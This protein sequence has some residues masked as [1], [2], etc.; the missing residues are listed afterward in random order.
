MSN[1]LLKKDLEVVDTPI[2]LFDCTMSNGTIERWSSAKVFFAGHW[3]EPRVLD[4]TALDVRTGGDDGLDVLSQVVLTLANAD[5][6]ASQL[7]RQI[8]FKGARLLVRFVFVDM[9]TGSSSSDPLTLFRGL[10][11]A[12]EESTESA[13]RV[14]F[15]NRLS[16][17]RQLV[18]QLRIQKRC[19]WS[20]PS[21]AAERAEGVSGLEQG[22]YSPFFRCG[23]SPDQADGVGNLNGA[24]PFTS[25]DYTRGSCE[26]RGMFDQDHLLRPTRR[27]GGLEFVPASIAVRTAGEASGKMSNLLSNDARYNDF[28]PSVYGTA[29]YEP[30]I[31][32]ARNDGNLT[33]FEVLLGVGEIE[34]VVKVI[35]NDVEIPAGV[36]GAN[37]TGTGWYNTPT[38][39]NRTG[40]FNV[41]FSGA[42]GNPLG[43]PYGSMA[44]L[45]LVVPNRISDG[46]RL[47]SVKLLIQGL[48]L[49][50]F[51]N[52]GGYLGESFTSNPAWVLLDLLRRAGWTTDELDLGEFAKAAAHCDE[53]VTAKDLMG[54]DVQLSRYQCNLVLRRRRSL[55]E[56]L[57][58]VSQSA[59]LFLT[60]GP[61]GKLQAR[62]ES[63]I[64]VSQP[65]KQAGS[66]STAP[67][68]GGWPIYEFDESGIVRGER[69][70]PEFRIW[71][72]ST[73]DSPNRVTLEFQDAFNEYQQDSLSFAD[74]EDVRRTGQEI[75]A[76]TNALG[77]ANLD[78]AARLIRLQLDKSIR[79]NTYVEFESSVKALAIRPGDLITI[80]Y[81]KEG[82]SRQ[83]FRV[84]RVRPRSNYSR[85][86]IQ[87]QI[88]DEGWYLQPGVGGA[89]S[90]RQ[91]SAGI[92]TP[93][94]LVGFE[95]NADG[96]PQ[97]RVSEEA[98]DDSVQVSIQFRP[99]ASLTD[100]AAS[101]PLISLTAEVQTTG[102][103]LA[104]GRSLYYA[105]SAEDAEGHETPLSFVVRAV[106]PDGSNTNQVVLKKLS[107]SSN[108]ST[109]SVYRGDNPQQLFRIGAQLPL[110][111][112]FH[113]PGLA[114]TL[115]A[116]PDPNFHEARFYWRVEV[117]PETNA[118]Q[119]S[120]TTVGNSTLSMPAGAFDGMIVRI[121]GGRGAGQERRIATNSPTAVATTLPWS[122]VPDASS[123][124]VIAENGW[125]LG[126][127]S[128]NSPVSFPIPNRPGVT[129]EIQG[130]AANV[131][132][133]EAAPELSPLSRWQIIGAGGNGSDSGVPGTPTFGLAAVGGGTVELGGIGF[134][135]LTNTRTIAGGTLTLYFWNELLAP[136]SWAISSATTAA[137]DVISAN[138]PDPNLQ[139]GDLLQLDSEIVRVAAIASNQLSFTVERGVFGSEASAHGVDTPMY[140]L[141]KGLFVAPFVR[142]FFG[143]PASGKYSHP[144]YLPDVRIAC[145]EFFV[146]NAFGD[147]AIARGCVTGNLTKGIRTLSGGQLTFQYDGSLAIGSSLAPILVADRDHTVGDVYAVLAEPPAGGPVELEIRRN[148]AAYC[149]LTISPGFT[150]SN[151]VDGFS[152]GP[153][154]AGDRLTLDV[155]SVPPSSAGTPGRDLT[156]I[157]TR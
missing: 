80:S 63:R 155:L 101:I 49:S 35:V 84:L 39:G 38:R 17:S 41:D 71:S 146:T 77:V 22:K 95:Y 126:A 130:L 46:K 83:L 86:S 157:L 78:Q 102:G 150:A 140:R 40:G 151:L 76:A 70:E 131:A 143:S 154:R 1:P 129:V 105:V 136:H 12:P 85:V 42:N 112:V 20:F 124:F 34:S 23:Y 90:R 132:G 94:P 120:A 65:E 99:P 33:R 31:V 145:A 15:S 75:A 43:D 103:A 148:G 68:F 11:N 107:F 121:T 91:G 44:Y 149:G 137:S 134:G 109:F 152:K 54:N 135:D 51:G 123:V 138:A 30:P 133:Q 21:T 28:V 59:G 32:F 142:G 117:M 13:M 67:L 82:L 119:F 56:V 60:Y 72:R 29:W 116:P 115:V 125:K 79:G 156:V 36:T 97:F 25:C 62:I 100:S 118:N 141:E 139:V 110:A 37:M 9:V 108:S 26:A 48:R 27:F 93:R 18:P 52:D 10:A 96:Q 47:P 73:A 81:A 127:F 106:L 5:S 8:G 24:E 98:T 88:H 114:N 87:A 64:A 113:D 4:H 16:P 53:Q 7:E 55:A 58:G 50:T 104:G 69:G 147:S 14:S 89:A 6:Y 92:G 111:S 57:R 3:Y 128:G 2:M 19:S 153:L 74:L 66:N 144:I 122:I 45:S 61:E